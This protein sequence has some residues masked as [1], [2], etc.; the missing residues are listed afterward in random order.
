[1]ESAVIGRQ[2]RQDQNAR[3]KKIAAGRGRF[4]R[5]R[6]VNFGGAKSNGKGD[7]KLFGS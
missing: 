5:F 7:K 1:M 6:K 4:W 2:V 3:N